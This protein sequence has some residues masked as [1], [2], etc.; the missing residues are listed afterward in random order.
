MHL[1]W[2]EEGGKGRGG[3]RTSLTHGLG[4]LDPCPRT[5]PVITCHNFFSKEGLRSTQAGK[6][7]R[8]DEN[9]AATLLSPSLEKKLGHVMTGNV[10]GHGSSRPSA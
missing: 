4:W 9:D 7:H 3:L 2:A 6:F 1:G 5:F 8:T 10:L